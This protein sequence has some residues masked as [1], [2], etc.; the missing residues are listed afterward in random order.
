MSHH[1]AISARL[2]RNTDP[3]PL[4]EIK[5]SFDGHPTYGETL[6]TH[7]LKDIVH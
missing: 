1:E 2:P 7:G 3:W 5:P 6:T 4:I